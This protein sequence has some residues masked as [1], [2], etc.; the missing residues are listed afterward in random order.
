LNH[1]PDCLILDD[2][3]NNKTRDSEAFTKQV[4]DHL[5]E[6]MAGMATDGFMLYLG[7]YLTEYGNIQKLFDRA[8]VDKNIRMRNV[9]LIIGDKP[10]WEDKYCMTDIESKLTGKV[11]IEAKRLQL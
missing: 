8:K 7:N 3:E 4:A 5:T 2:I 6:A 10:A 9:P 11:S 1:R